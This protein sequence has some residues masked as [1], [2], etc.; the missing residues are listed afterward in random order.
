[1][2]ILLVSIGSRGDMEPFLALGELLKEEGHQV[3]AVFPEQFKPLAFDTGIGFFSLGRKFIE[4]LESKEGKDAMGGSSTGLRK[5]IAYI[6]LGTKYANI[7][8]ELIRRQ[9]EAIENEKPDRILFSGKAIY[10]MIWGMKNPG[11]TILISPVPYLLHPVKERSHIGF[12]GNYGT[13]LNKLTY[14]IA[15]LG[16]VQTVYASSKKLNLTKKFSRSALL[17]GLKNNKCIYTISPSLFHKPDYWP[18]NVSVLGY[19]ERNKTI[20]WQP[21]KALEKFL[22]HY[23]KI[24]FIT[25]GSMANPKPEEKTKIIL[26]TV[27]KLKIPTI[28]NSAGGGILQPENYSSEHIHFVEQVPYDWVFPK[29]YA[30]VHHGGSGTTH[31]AVKNGCASLIIPHIIDQFMWNDELSSLGV[32]PKGM[33]ITRL[34]TPELESKIQELWYNPSYKEKAVLLSEKMKKEDFREAIYQTIIR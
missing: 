33:P 12:R 6:K 15:N 8:K 3:I 19:H 9:Y 29:M 7:N 23:D 27:S 2:K 17:N 14:K 25:F 22:Q 24:L 34:N 4:M 1:M 16:L 30:V 11:K 10:P 5:I 18:S 13:F 28:I 31:M 26:D 20:N 21:D 32:G